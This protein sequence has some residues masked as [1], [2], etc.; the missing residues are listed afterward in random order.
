MFAYA[1]MLAALASLFAVPAS[2]ETGFEARVLAALNAARQSPAQY[3]AGLRHY[4]GFF[5]ANL[6]TQPGQAFDVE[7]IEGV[8]PVDEA[9]GYLSGHRPL[10]AIL[11]GSTLAAAA[12]DEATGQA[13]SGAVGHGDDQG[14]SPGDRAMR[15][16]GGPYVAEA[17]MY[18]AAD[19]EDVVRQLIVDDGVADRGH[20]TILFSPGLRFAGIACRSHPTYRTV[21]VID[22]AETPDGREANASFRMA[23]R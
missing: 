16:G 19:A 14:G 8:A 10:P 18:G 11:P 7:T 1:G 3:A 12:G 4:R 22:L 6:V 17:I 21:C 15:R 2:G 20:R 23:S 13:R 5:H 9:I